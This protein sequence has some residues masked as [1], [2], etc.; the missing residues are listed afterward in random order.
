M[1]TQPHEIE[2]YD[3]LAGTPRRPQTGYTYEYLLALPEDNV[4]REIIG[5]ELI[6]A[7]SPMLRHQQIVAE[8]VGILLA[9]KKRHG[10]LVLPAPMDVL[11][12]PS[13]VVQ[14]DV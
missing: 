6:V 9:Y 7:P 8:L 10:G 3:E 4:R 1:A 5:G 13:D 12:T 14:P 2:L 11:F